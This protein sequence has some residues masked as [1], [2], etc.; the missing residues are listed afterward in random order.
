MVVL[1]W[2]ILGVVL[3][4]VEMHHLQFFALFGAAGAF[5]AALVA[6]IAPSAYPAQ[7]AVAVLVAAV[8]MI[9]VR[10][11]VSDALHRRY[12][13]R[14]GRGVHGTLV[15]EEVLTLDVVGDAHH[16]GH[17]KLVGERWLAVSGSG[18]RIPPGTKVLVT[19]VEGTTLTVWPVDGMDHPVV[20]GLDAG[21][22]SPPATTPPPANPA[23]RAEGDTP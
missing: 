16:V 13:G 17:V 14:L 6:A 4:A 18:T 20:D 12:E 21:P 3:L 19:A 22:A 2:L 8:G 10:P 15:G 23:E 7:V 1:A 9:A 5:A 11:F